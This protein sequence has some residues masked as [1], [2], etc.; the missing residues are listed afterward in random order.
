MAD[1]P[2]II[3]IAISLKIQP[4]DGPVFYKV[5]G[6]R[7][8]QSRTIKL[9]TGSKYKIEVIVKPGSAEATTMGIGGKSFPLEQQSKD[10]EQVVYN[11]PYDTEGVPH[12]KSGDR[13]PVQVFIEFKDAGMFETVWQVKYY[14]YY[15]RE[16]CQFGNSFNCIEYEA[17]PN[18]TRS[19][20][21]IN[22]E[23]F[24]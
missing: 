9:L 24:Q 5:D 15:K 7:F 22:K 17:K 14:N 1:V 2:A 3:N 19:L 16:H 10:E 12:T 6:T 20:M 23:V 18:E 11:G 21:W 4:N 13:Q 8:G